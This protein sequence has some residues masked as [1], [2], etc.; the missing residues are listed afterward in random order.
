MHASTAN[1]LSATILL[2]VGLWVIA[3]ISAFTSNRG[4]W[5]QERQS[6]LEAQAR[7]EVIAAGDENFADELPGGDLRYVPPAP[8]TYPLY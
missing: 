3:L 4:P 6:E 5:L 8:I 7:A 2:L 1:L